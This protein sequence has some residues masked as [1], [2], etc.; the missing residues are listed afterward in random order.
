MGRQITIA[1]VTGIVW[2]LM[3]AMMFDM[4]SRNIALEL[5]VQAY[6]DRFAQRLGEDEVYGAYNLLTLDKGLTWWEFDADE[7]PDGLEAIMI[8]GRADAELVRRLDERD[9]NDRTR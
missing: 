7:L 4:K 3:T 1:I 8:V 6:K 9:E 5:T 2:G